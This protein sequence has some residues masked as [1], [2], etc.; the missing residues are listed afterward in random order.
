M[1]KYDQ[2]NSVIGEGSVFE[3]KFYISGSLKIDGKFEGEIKTED[4]LVVG[5]T[6]R[7]KTNIM[8]KEVVMAGALIGDVEAKVSV[9]LTNSGRMLGN[10]KTPS[11]YLSE[12]VVYKG[13]VN[14][15]SG[16]KQEAEKIVAGCFVSDKKES[17]TTK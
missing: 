6:G 2:I 13:N 5:P 9:K 8:A 15:T 7:V 3:G 10:I 11:L 16:S 1:A 12:G 17:L 14:I 4:T